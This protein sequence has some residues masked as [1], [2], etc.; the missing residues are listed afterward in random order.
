MK[1]KSV[2]PR[3]VLD[4]IKSGKRVYVLDKQT[5]VVHTMNELSLSTALKIT[6]SPEDG[7]YEFWYE[8]YEGVDDAEL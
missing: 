3:W 1:Y 5:Q 8:V 4:D 7:R 6:E 2:Y